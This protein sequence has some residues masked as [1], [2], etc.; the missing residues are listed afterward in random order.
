MRGTLGICYL[1]NKSADTLFKFIYLEGFIAGIFGVL[2]GTA[3]IYF[4]LQNIVL[5]RQ[6]CVSYNIVNDERKLW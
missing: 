6:V 2:V 3:F 5:T 4:A 1:S